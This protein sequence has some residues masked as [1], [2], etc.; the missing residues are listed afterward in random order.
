V[1]GYDSIWM[2]PAF[3]D[4]LVFVRSV[5]KLT[6]RGAIL[7]WDVRARPSSTWLKFGLAQP[8][9]GLSK[10]RNQVEVEAEVEGGK[11]TGV[12]MALPLRTAD[13]SVIAPV[14]ARGVPRELKA[15][16]AGRWQGEVDMEWERGAET[17]R[18]DLDTSGPAPTGTYQRV[19]SALPN[20]SVRGGR[21]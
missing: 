15:P 14:R 1:G 2:R 20:E 21:E 12:F 11:V 16:V 18:F 3:A 10:P 5:D 19:V 7:C 8:I 9:Q 13:A 4:G 17:W 6:S